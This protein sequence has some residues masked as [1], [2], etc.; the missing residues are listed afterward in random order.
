MVSVS[1]CLSA[2][3]DDKSLLLFNTIG[4]GSQDTS[5]LI[6]RLGLTRKQYYSRLSGMINSSL[7]ERKNGKYSLASLGKIVYE[8]QRL[9]G[10]AVQCSSKL[11]AIDSI[12]RS[13]IPV[14]QL[15]RIIDTLVID[16]KIKE[17]LISSV[18]NNNKHV[19][20]EK[21]ELTVPV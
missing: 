12:E 7:I 6:S 19:S 8:A 16:S 1:A 18:H 15:N 4:L 5:I 21:K 9:I 20:P 14:E 3:S 13:E 11:A 2:I 10:K 17:I